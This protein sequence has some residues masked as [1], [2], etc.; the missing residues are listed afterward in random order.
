MSAALST[1][2]KIRKLLNEGNLSVAKIAEKLEV[3]PAYVYQVRYKDNAKKAAKKAARAANHTETPEVLRELGDFPVDTGEPSGPAPVYRDMALD[4]AI[5]ETETILEDLRR[6]KEQLENLAPVL[7]LI[8]NG[9]EE[10]H[11]GLTV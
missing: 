3:K 10:V 5:A 1:T 8:K 4:E 7:R 6:A 2:D 11:S 9:H